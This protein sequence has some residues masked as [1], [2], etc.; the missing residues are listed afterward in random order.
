MGKQGYSGQPLPPNI[1]LYGVN[2]PNKM[3]ADDLEIWSLAKNL[4]AMGETPKK[5]K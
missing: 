5:L 2:S 3:P 4:P 1:S